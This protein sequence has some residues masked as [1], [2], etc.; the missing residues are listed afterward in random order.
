MPRSLPKGGTPPTDVQLEGSHTGQ[1]TSHFWNLFVRNEF[2]RTKELLHLLPVDS[3]GR[4]DDQ[5]ADL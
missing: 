5:Q 3:L 4:A 1:T 2:D